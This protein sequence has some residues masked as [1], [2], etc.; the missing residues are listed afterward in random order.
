M[1]IRKDQKNN[2]L[3][4]FFPEIVDSFEAK[5]IAD[6]ANEE[7]IFF[8]HIAIFYLCKLCPN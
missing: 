6:K 4:N 8:N 7:I 1:D 5:F 2:F 3:I